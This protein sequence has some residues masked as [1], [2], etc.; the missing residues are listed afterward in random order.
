MKVFQN[1]AVL[2]KILWL[3]IGEVRGECTRL[4]K[5]ELYCLSSSP[6]GTQMIK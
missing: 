3:K 1:R 6:T 5:E 4:P 2:R